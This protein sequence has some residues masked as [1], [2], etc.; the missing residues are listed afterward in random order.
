LTQPLPT[1]P[2]PAVLDL[3]LQ[4]VAAAVGGLRKQ[5]QYATQRILALYISFAG[6]LGN[7]LPTHLR[8]TFADAAAQVIAAVAF[9]NRA[10]LQALVRQALALGAADAA[11]TGTAAAAAAAAQP[12]RPEL[13]D[14]VQQIVG[15]L[16]QRVFATI[17]SAQ[18]LPQILRPGD[19]KTVMVI[20][21]KLNE[22]GN[23]A[24]RDTRWAVNAAYNQSFRDRADAQRVPV[25][26]VAEFD[27]CLHCLAYSGEVA[28]P[29]RPFPLDLTFYR[30][31]AGD[32]KPLK[33]PPSRV[34]WGPPLHPNCV[35][36]GTVVSG[37]PVEIAYRRWHAGELVELRTKNGHVLSVTPNHPILTPQGWIEAGLLERGSHV[38]RR[39]WG[40]SFALGPDENDQPALIEQVFGAAR[41]ALGVP[42][43]RVPVTA[44]HFHGDGVDGDVDVVPTRRFLDRGGQIGQPLQQQ[45]FVGASGFGAHLTGAGT[46]FQQALGSRTARDAT[47]AS[48]GARAV[49]LGGLVGGDNLVGFSPPTDLDTGFLEPLREGYP[50]DPAGSRKL[51]DALAGQI[52]T[53]EIVQVVRVAFAGHVYNLQTSDGWYSANGI[54]THN[55]RCSLELYLGSDNYPVMPWETEEFTVAQAL[56]REAERT[57]LRGEAG[58]DSQPALVRA[59]SALLSRGTRLPVTHQRRARRAIKTGRFR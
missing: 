35:P 48:Q 34:L 41:V 9:T 52:T 25:V 54:I 46:L 55:C 33:H 31:P 2:R 23:I 40:E 1:A 7:E 36:A 38:V 18:A 30:D 39:R 24:E 45:A 5:L 12:V 21:G 15:T 27:A 32:P 47:L 59:A 53:D 37:P 42:S 26:W 58:V 11:Y 17:A 19:H 20:V 29:G 16:A 44:E 28:Q 4:A 49:L 51:L 50:T 56:K 8:R 3:E 43:V 57:V 13:E 10:T 14:W 22:A 6:S